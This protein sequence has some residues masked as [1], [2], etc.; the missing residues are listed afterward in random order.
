MDW[1]AGHAPAGASATISPPTTA[2]EHAPEAADEPSTKA[3]D[4]VW[5]MHD[6]IAGDD[7]SASAC[8]GA[9]EADPGAAP[10]EAAD[11]TAA[12]AMAEDGDASGD[13]E[14]GEAAKEEAD[15]GAASGVISPPHHACARRLHGAWSPA[16]S[17]SACCAVS[18]HHATKRG[19]FLRAGRFRR[20]EQGGTRVR[21]RRERT[22]SRRPEWRGQAVRGR[23]GPFPHA[24]VAGQWQC[25]C[26]GR[27]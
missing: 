17:A 25:Q 9:A 1:D 27:R 6:A 8:R 22:W 12:D 14:G 19:A 5:V 23:T 26:G 11:G 2:P 13:D 15:R 20:G 7:A 10:L 3:D 18:A 4:Q 16:G 24:Q 21:G